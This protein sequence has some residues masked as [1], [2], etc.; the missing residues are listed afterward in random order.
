[1]KVIRTVAH[2][3]AGVLGNPS[4]GYFGRTISIIVRNFSARVILYEWPELEIIL[5]QEDRCLFD[6]LDD[7]VQDVRL[8]GYY[9]GLRLVK[10][11][12]KRFADYAA[13]QGIPLHGKNF[14]LRY[15]TDIPRQVG[16]A[17]SSAIITAV[18]RAIMQF[19]EVSL[20]REVLPSLQLIVAGVDQL[21][22]LV[23]GLGTV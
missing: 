11:A 6:R 5:S 22:Y 17:G 21:E 8:H 1:M 18:F 16:L 12:I 2:A 3:R 23:Q 14:A 15:E 19:Y 20:P 13:Y 4:D 10:A 7:L 9:G